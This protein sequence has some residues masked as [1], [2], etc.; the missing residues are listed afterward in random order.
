MLGADGIDRTPCFVFTYNKAFL[1]KK[2]NGRYK[3]EEVS[4]QCRQVAK[5]FN[6]DEERV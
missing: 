6:I 1:L 4:D 5:D 2:E 3:Y